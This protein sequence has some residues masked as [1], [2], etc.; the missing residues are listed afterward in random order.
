MNQSEKEALAKQAE[1]SLMSG[2][3]EQAKSLYARLVEIDSE[4][5]EAWLMLAAAQ[6]E[7][8]SLDEALRSAQRNLRKTFIG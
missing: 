5:E 4:N 1:A 2:Q 7:T 3:L 8:G 6:G